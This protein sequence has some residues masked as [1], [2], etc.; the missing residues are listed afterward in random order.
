MASVDS[1]PQRQQAAL[2]AL[3]RS[4]LRLMVAAAQAEPAEP[5]SG[6]SVHGWPGL[7]ALL[8]KPMSA[9]PWLDAVLAACQGEAPPD[10]SDPASH[11]PGAGIPAGLP[12]ASGLA[13]LWRQHPLI[14]T[15]LLAIGAATLWQQRSA[16]R[17]ALGS[18]GVPELLCIF[19]LQAAP[20]V[21]HWLHEAW[22]DHP[23]ADPAPDAAP[24]TTPT[25]TPTPTT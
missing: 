1:L 12:T 9:A 13:R 25:S 4:R 11:R 24:P 21:S 19:G 2:Q 16:L 3:Q 10:P 5:A 6:A 22:D 20:W 8:V 18:E 14:G 23:S 15:G 7:L 17:R